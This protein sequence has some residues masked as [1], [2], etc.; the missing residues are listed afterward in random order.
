MTQPKKSVI[1]IT[2]VGQ[3]FEF[4]LEMI[5]GG[6]LKVFFCAPFSAIFKSFLEH[7]VTTDEKLF[8][9]YDLG[10]KQLSV[11][12]RRLSSPRPM[13]FKVPQISGK[14]LRI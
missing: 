2:V 9:C 14:K 12:W 4:R 5:S 3:I 10:T 8:Y 1:Q 7:F 13:K 6:H 11:Q